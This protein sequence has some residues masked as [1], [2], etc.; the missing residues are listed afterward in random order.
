[1]ARV[2]IPLDY[3]HLFKESLWIIKFIN[4]RS[5]AHGYDWYR[6]VHLLTDL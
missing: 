1:M 3:L 2:L 6:W 4:D 5:P